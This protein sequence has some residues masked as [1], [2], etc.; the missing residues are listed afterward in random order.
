[1]LRPT[2]DLYVQLFPGRAVVEVPGTGRREEIAGGG[3]DHP[4]VVLGDWAAANASLKAAIAR[5][6]PSRWHRVR[7]ALFHVQHE[8]EGGLTEVEL[9]ALKDLALDTA[10]LRSRI[11]LYLRPAVLPGDEVGRLLAATP[12]SEVGLTA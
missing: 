8:W 4:R 11:N 3:F 9:R 7:R 6:A 2:F 1:M 12:G 5:V 10:G